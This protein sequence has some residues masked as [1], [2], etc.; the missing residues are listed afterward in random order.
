[1]KCIRSNR[2][3]ELV[4]KPGDAMLKMALKQFSK[5][6]PHGSFESST[7][8]EKGDQAPDGPPTSETG[9]IAKR[10][11]KRLVVENDFSR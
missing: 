5:L 1:M 6:Q 10:P 9:C 4:L 2:D 7:F 8:A 11:N 3:T